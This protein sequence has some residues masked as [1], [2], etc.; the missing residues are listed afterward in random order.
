MLAPELPLYIDST[1]IVCFRSCPRKFFNEFVLGLRGETISID[2][3]AGGCFATALETLYNC[4][5]LHQMPLDTALMMAE[6]E[7][8]IKWGDREPESYF[9]PKTGEKIYKSA[10]TRERTWEVFL[11][12][13]KK[14]PPE[15]DHVQPLISQGRPTVEFSFALPLTHES[16][17]YDFPLHPSGQPFLYS[18]RFDMLGLY[19][20]KPVVKDEKTMGKTPPANWSET[21]DL[22]NQFIGYVWACRHLGIP[23][24][25]VVVR[26]VSIMKETF[27]LPEV[28]KSG[29]YTDVL[30]ERW[31]HQLARDLFRLVDCWNSD[32]FDYNMADTCTSYG[33][34]Q[35]LHACRADDPDIWLKDFGVRRWNPLSKFTIDEVKT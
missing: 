26:G 17:G 32:Y 16:T 1:M 22:R 28:L 5:H 29:S 19:D 23:V 24:A 6:G 8:L 10:K 33:M 27:H 21:F 4:F 20:N 31:K 7:F 2:L 15:T 25:G 34:C 35:F 12:Y 9:S 3:H 14:W 30:L 11:E 18:G 13:I